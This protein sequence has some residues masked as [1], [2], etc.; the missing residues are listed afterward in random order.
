MIESFGNE[1]I[2][3]ISEKLCDVLNECKGETELAISA[4]M[5][6]M[7]NCFMDH[8]MDKDY[9]IRQ[10]DRAWDHYHEQRK[11]ECASADSVDPT[12][13]SYS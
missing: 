8:E 2:G 5:H 1:K 13:A 3:E 11:E 7:V 10:C 12:K 6:L 4:M 9:F